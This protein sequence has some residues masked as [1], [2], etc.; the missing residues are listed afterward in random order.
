V[1]L[2]EELAA[3]RA[4][5]AGAASDAKLS[6]AA[7]GAVNADKAKP[8]PKKIDVGTV[9]AMGVA[10][11]AIGTLVTTLIGQATG[12]FTLPFWLLCLA[13]AG[14]LL[15]ISGPSMIIAWLKLRKRNLGPILDA[16]G[17]AV[18]AKARLNVP[19]GASLTGVAKLPVGAKASADDKFGEKPNTWVPV[20]KFVIIVCFIFSLLNHFYVWDMIVYKATGKHYPEFLRTQEADKA[21]A[22][23]KTEEKKKTEAAAAAAATNAPAA[24]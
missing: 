14:L 2:F 8:E 16:N 6:A 10:F 7:T 18:N 5:A 24:K 15:V 17:W 11:G 9:A 22:E 1:R 13:I 20:V 23:K 21:A 3:K 4:A 19:F 12:L